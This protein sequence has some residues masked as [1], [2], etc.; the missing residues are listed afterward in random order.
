M[1]T[2]SQNQPEKRRASRRPALPLSR[3]GGPRP[4][5]PALVAHILSTLP[6][7]LLVAHILSTLPDSLARR[8]ELLRDLAASIPAGLESAVRVRALQFHLQE[9]QRLRSEWPGQ[10]DQP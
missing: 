1:K 8:E 5:P 7:S 2:S 9:H 4:V 3:G 10:A 6:D